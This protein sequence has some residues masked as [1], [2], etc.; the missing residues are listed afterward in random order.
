[1]N[2]IHRVVRPDESSALGGRA[3]VDEESVAELRFTASLIASPSSGD[4]NGRS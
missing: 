3:Y 2:D 1:M 4:D